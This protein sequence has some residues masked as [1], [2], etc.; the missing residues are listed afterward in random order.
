[1]KS[2]EGSIS[3]R[4]SLVY[5]ANGETSSSRG[6]TK[7]DEEQDRLRLRQADLARQRD[8]IEEKQPTQTKPSKT[9]KVTIKFQAPYLDR[10]LVTTED[11]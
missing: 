3:S 2:N 7:L 10:P 4:P 11:G 9:K 8:E 5:Q 6:R 1:M